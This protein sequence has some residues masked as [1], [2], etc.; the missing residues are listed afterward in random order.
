MPEKTKIYRKNGETAEMDAVD[1]RRAV[2]THP[3][4]WALTAWPKAEK[5]KVEQGSGSGGS[6]PFEAKHR[7]AGSYSVVDSDGKEVLE[8]LTKED[9]EL[10]NAGTL[11]EQKAYIEAEQAKRASS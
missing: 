2:Q 9:A 4:D 1:A 5:P 10:F 6:K 3:D 11:D 8:K 7:G